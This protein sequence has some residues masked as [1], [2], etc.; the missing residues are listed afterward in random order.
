MTPARHREVHDQAGVLR[1]QD[2]VLAFENAALDGGHYGL[3]PRHGYM[4]QRIPESELNPRRGERGTVD[5]RPGHLD[6]FPGSDS[7]LK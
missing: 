7:N 6:F 2:S 5:N 3:T 1:C 4:I